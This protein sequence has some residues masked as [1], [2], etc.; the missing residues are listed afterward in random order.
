M[1]DQDRGRYTSCF[2]KLFRNLFIEEVK[3]ECPYGHRNQEREKLTRAKRSSVSCMTIFREAT[4]VN[5]AIAMILIQSS[6]TIP[7]VAKRRTL[8]SV[9][10]GTLNSVKSFC[11]THHPNKNQ[12]T[13]ATPNKEAIKVRGVSERKLY[14]PS[15]NNGRNQSK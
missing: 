10:K 12:Y 8:K 2:Q 5:R 11:Q 6:N 1:G 15:Q 13:V 3:A 7:S 9:E 4:T 14:I